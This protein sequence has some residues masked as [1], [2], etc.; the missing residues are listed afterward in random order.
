[1]EQLKRLSERIISTSVRNYNILALY[2]CD[3]NW[4]GKFL[5]INFFLRIEK[6]Y[7]SS[8]FWIILIFSPADMQL[9]Y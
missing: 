7:F 2:M 3:S 5:R 4:I 8:N 9:A 1:M 6:R